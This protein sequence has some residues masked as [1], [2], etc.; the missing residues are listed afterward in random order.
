[1]LTLQQF[2]HHSSSLSYRQ[3][4]H[5]LSSEY[6]TL[7]KDFHSSKEKEGTV[8]LSA[9]LFQKST[10]FG[11]ILSTDDLHSLHSEYFFVC[12]RG[13]GTVGRIQYFCATNFL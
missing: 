10:E 5:Y 2:Q 9:D 6:L 13:G 8:L 11:L 3:A 4:L 7:S 1:M 12:G